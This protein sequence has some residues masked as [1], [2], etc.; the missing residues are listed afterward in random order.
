MSPKVSVW[1]PKY[2]STNHALIIKT[3]KI[4]KALDNG[5]LACEECF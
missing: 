4:Q 2:H 1:F 3:E 5:K